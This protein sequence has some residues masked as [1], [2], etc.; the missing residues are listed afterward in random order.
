MSVAP[1]E[2][3]L[4]DRRAA[5]TRHPDAVALD[6]G[7][8]ITAVLTL[9]KEGVEVGGIRCSTRAALDKLVPSWP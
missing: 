4:V 3:G 7:G 2:D 9:L 6:L 1:R 5:R 8:E